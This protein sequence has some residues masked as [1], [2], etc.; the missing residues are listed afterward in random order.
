MENNFLI[1]DSPQQSS[2]NSFSLDYRRVLYRALRYWYVVAVALA[3][4]LVIAFLI[5]RYTTKIYPITASIIIRET[6][7]SA[8]AKIL[9]NNPLVNAYR[10]YYNELHIIR[11]YP[12]MTQV[13][14]ELQF[15][16]SIQKKGDIK[17]TEQY[18]TSPF[19]IQLIEKK[20]PATLSIEF[21]DGVNFK[22]GLIDAG[23][24]SQFRVNDTV[25]CNGVT[26]VVIP[27]TDLSAR[28][29]EE[30]I[31]RIQD[32]VVV[33]GSYINRLK[34]SWAE[35]GASV[36]NLDINGAVTQKEMDFLSKLI[37]HY[38][39]YD[40]NKKN[41]TARRSLAFIDEQLSRI[42][43]SLSTF[44]SELESF[45]KQNFVTDLS[46]EAQELYD[47]LKV[48]GEQRSVLVYAGNYYGYLEEYLKKSNDY[49]QIVLP[50]TIGVA[51]PVLNT[52][53]GQL[54]T[55][56]MEYN[57]LNA[58][59]FRNAL[60]TEKLTAL[61]N[62]IQ[63][64]K[65][66]LIEALRGVRAT[67]NIKISGLNTKINTLQANLKGLPSAQRR[68]VNIQ[69]NYTLNE[70]LYI[71]L[72]QKRAEAGISEASTTSDIMVVNP[73]RIAGGPITPQI[74]QNYLIYGV[75]GLLL[76]FLIFVLIEVFNDRLQSKE[77]VEKLTSI[78]FIGGIG[79]NPG[80]TN[81]VVYEKPKSALAESFRAL[82]SNLNFFTEGKQKK[83]FMI[84]SSLSGEGKSFTTINLATVFSLAGHKTLIIGADLRKP[85]IFNDFGLTNELG[86]SLYLSGLCEMKDII[87]KTKIESLDIITGGPIPPNPSELL[88][89]T[90]MD[91]LIEQLKLQY[92]FILIDTP[93]LSLITDGLELAKYADHVVF[94]VRQNYTPRPILKLAHELY[95]HGK[96]KNLSIVLNDVYRVG[97]G[98][99]YGYS[100]GY[101]YGYGYGSYG[102]SDGYYSDEDRKSGTP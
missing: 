93:P 49:E 3:T 5:N 20:Q 92:D 23:V 86:L 45:K 38:Q 44:E 99:G 7:E 54:V 35:A 65:N 17:S 15:Q 88:L 21:L 81:L 51:D 76:P 26:F 89:G 46:A 66:Q 42:R 96:I 67:D 31:V 78:P 64:I 11:S 41:Q 83:V 43:D 73:P 84:T 87:Q 14:E 30:Y 77:D 6:E 70:N 102:Q 61:K 10:N 16:V 79:H 9:Y 60:V 33:A 8:E 32:P 1:S 90:R 56:Q 37:T 2:R 27:Q 12:L 29:S 24:T 57:A 50:S 28:K 68:L 91:H 19:R 4:G 13:V 74:S 59:A 62:G 53:V 95:A 36:V 94:I 98:Y 97:P 100:Y 85:K 39:E 71:F 22:C 72:L 75:A 18:N 34:I 82:R 58:S 52:L 25:T 48:Y 40:L 80:T 69:R 47:E 63:N 55:Y 101:G